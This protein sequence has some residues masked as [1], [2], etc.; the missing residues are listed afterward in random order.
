MVR[1]KQEGKHESEVK[2]LINTSLRQDEQ[3]ARYNLAA[4]HLCMYLIDISSM[5]VGIG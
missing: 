1:G 3:K 2:L 5:Q 4:L